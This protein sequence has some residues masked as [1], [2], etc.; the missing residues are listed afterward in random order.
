MSIITF[1]H[2]HPRNLELFNSTNV[3]HISFPCCTKLTQWEPPPVKYAFTETATNNLLEK[4]TNIFETLSSEN[5]DEVPVTSAKELTDT[6]N[7]PVVQPQ[8]LK[9]LTL[10]LPTGMVPNLWLPISSIFLGSNVASLLSLIAFSIWVR[11]FFSSWPIPVPAQSTQLRQAKVSSFYIPILEH[12][13]YC[14]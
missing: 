4:T 1:P 12:G 8:F 2:I 13:C 3:L 7:Q 5:T 10:L 14:N 11:P 6:S 9:W